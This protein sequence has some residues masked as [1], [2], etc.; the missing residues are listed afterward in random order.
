MV[1]RRFV[2]RIAPDSVTTT[3][4]KEHTIMKMYVGNLPFSAGRAELEELFS[5]YGPI[6]DIHVAVDRDT[7]RPRGFAFV[8]IGDD[9]RANEAMNNLNGQEVE[10]RKI[11]VNEARPREER[12]RSFGGGGGYRG[13]NARGNHRSGGHRS[14]ERRGSG[15]SRF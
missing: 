8:T 2:N 9:A 15:R 7:N 4:Q 12:P 3:T 6:E 14:H 13:G 11:I 5:P 1:H 10:G